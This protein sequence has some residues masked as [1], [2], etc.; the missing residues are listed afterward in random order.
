MR[1]ISAALRAA[2]ESTAAY[3]HNL[4]VG[5]ARE[6]KLADALAPFIPERFGLA[7][8]IATNLRGERSAQ[9]DILVF[10][11]IAGAPFV[12]VREHVVLPVE[13][14]SA[15]IQVKTSLAPSGMD[16]V[17]A[18]LSSAK[19]L[20]SSEPRPVLSIGPDG[21]ASGTVMSKLFAC[22]VAYSAAESELD[23]MYA[24]AQANR[25]IADA[26]DRADAVLILDRGLIVWAS[27]G[28]E[29][30]DGPRRLAVPPG[31]ATHMAWIPAGEEAMLMLYLY[32]INALASHIQPGYSPGAYVEASGVLDSH[33]SWTGDLREIGFDVP[34]DRREDE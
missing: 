8:G 21:V 28:F 17:V 26:H 4:T 19:R 5:E 16:G 10:D 25:S 3:G 15:T 32:L 14:V 2:L 23:L 22:A 34:A 12:R 33:G 18:N 1:E 30:P 6:A 7:S 27:E 11:R 29:G 31:Q 24:F 9:Q 20:L 13:L